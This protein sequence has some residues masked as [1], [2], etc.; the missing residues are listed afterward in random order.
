[1]NKKEKMDFDRSLIFPPKLLS[2]YTVFGSTTVVESYSDINSPYYSFPYRWQI[3]INVYPQQHSNPDT[4][5]P[6]IYNAND[7][8]Q[9]MWIGQ[10]N[11]YTYKIVEIV[12][13]IGNE[14]L[15]VIVEDTD[16]LNLITAP[17]QTGNNAPAEDQSII[18]FNLDDNGNPI[19]NPIQSQ[20]SQ[21]P[22]YSY[23]VN[24]IE[25]RFRFRNY[26]QKYFY[27]DP[28]NNPTGLTGGDPVYLA[29]NSTFIKVN[30][31]SQSEVD[32]LF[33]FVRR[34]SSTSW[35]SDG[36]SFRKNNY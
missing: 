19:L 14:N 15:I 22:D 6:Y 26:Y 32:K 20:S 27:I 36:N 21:L 12:S 35:A 34:E 11:G 8:T 29:P 24:D 30:S 25:S 33:G 17:E 2:G 3:N 16:F 18:I 28:G 4:P 1:L 7:I 13:V 23:W 9:G 31:G 10:I 5:T